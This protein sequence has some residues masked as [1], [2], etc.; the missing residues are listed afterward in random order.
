MNPETKPPYTRQQWNALNE[1]E[2]QAVDAVCAYLHGGPLPRGDELTDSVL[3]TSLR[4]LQPADEVMNE[5]RWSKNP[6]W[7]QYRT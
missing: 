6:Q 2:Q 3:S 5:R 7:P 1:D 4:L